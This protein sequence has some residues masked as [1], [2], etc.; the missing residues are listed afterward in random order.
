M[1]AMGRFLSQ[2]S[3]Q[4]GKSE[5]VSHGDDQEERTS[6]EK[7]KKIQAGSINCQITIPKNWVVQNTMPEA[8]PLLDLALRRA[9]SV[10]ISILQLGKSRHREPETFSQPFGPRRAKT[11]V[12][13]MATRPPSPRLGP[14]WGL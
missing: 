12:T 3:L 14:F 4:E 8:K 13:A 11:E 7:K 9:T 5:A 10:I 2:N 1:S 6:G